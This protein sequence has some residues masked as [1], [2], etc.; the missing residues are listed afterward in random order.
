ML[1]L[2]RLSGPEDF[3]A[4]RNEWKSLDQSLS[5]RTPFTSPSW[6]ELWWTHFRRQS[7]LARDEFLACGLRDDVGRLVA[8]APLMRTDRPSFGVLRLREIQFFGADPNVTEL[9]GPICKPEDQA[10]VLRALSNHF[11]TTNEKWNWIRWQGVRRD[12]LERSNA[13]DEFPR[14]RWVRAVPAYILALPT[15]WPLFESALTRRVRKK[16]RACY[17]SLARDNHIIDFRVI[18]NSKDLAEPLDL[19]YSLHRARTQVRYF[20]VFSDPRARAFFNQ[21][22]SDAAARDELR[23]FQ[24][25]FN[26][27]V[28]ATR[29]GFSFGRELY[30][31]HSG[32][33]PAW[34]KYSIMTTLLAEIMKWAI[35][36]GVQV[37]NLSTGNDR[38]KTRWKPTEIIYSDGV[39]VAPGLAGDRISRAYEF[40]REQSHPG[41]KFR[42]LIG[43]NGVGAGETDLQSDE[44]APAGETD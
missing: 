15:A 38:S 13:L 19:F 8:V 24:L 17:K 37:L 29:V 7:R 1:T 40:L 33:D 16:L 34:D 11:A 9:R 14:F 35:G 23:I 18:R 32:N 5:P 28:V 27:V 21:Y 20:D 30:L 36:E 25:A 26:G 41:S 22:A 44:T 2:Q 12:L 39:E 43:Q 42:K 10:E 6:H 4:L 31:Y 3:A